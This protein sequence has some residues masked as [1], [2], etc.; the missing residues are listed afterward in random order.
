MRPR[1]GWDGYALDNVLNDRLRSCAGEPSL[2][3]QHHPMGDDRDS[4]FL[5][6]LRGHELQIIKKGEGLSGFGQGQRGAGAGPQLDARC[7]SG[8][9]HQLDRIPLKFGADT[10]LLDT[11]PKI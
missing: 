10:D 6:V 9:P 1:L 8:C 4:Q 5:D 2:R 3:I 11:V 7:G